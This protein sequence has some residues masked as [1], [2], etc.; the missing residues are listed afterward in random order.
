MSGEESAEQIK[1][2]ADRLKQE[3]IRLLKKRQ[4]R[5][6]R[7]RINDA[8]KRNLN[9][10]PIKTNYNNNK[11]NSSLTSKII[12]SKTYRRKK[13]RSQDNNK[14]IQKNYS[15]NE[16]SLS[17]NI[18][19]NK[20]ISLIKVP[21][22]ATSLNYLNQN[23][24]V[25]TYGENFDE[26]KYKRKYLSIENVE[27]GRIENHTETGLSKD[28]QYLISVTSA[29][30]IYNKKNNKNKN[31]YEYENEKIVNEKEEINENEN[32][33]D[34]NNI[35]DIPEKEVEEIIST[36]TIEKKNLGDNYK[37]YESKHLYK[38]NITSFTTYRRRKERTI[39]GNKQYETRKVKTYTIPQN[40]E[41]EEQN[42]PYIE[43][44]KIPYKEEEYI[45]GDKDYNYNEEGEEGEGEGE[46]EKEG[47][48]QEGGY[49][50]EENYE[51]E[52]GYYQ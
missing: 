52:E 26:K 27:D 45:L 35:C 41:F 20:I 7:E 17:P 48:R 49:E 15:S 34:D 50:E 14:Y 23:K 42:Q 18:K 47:E 33:N 36:V 24:K 6:K 12:K 43:N 29:E 4:E 44:S 5:L 28:G 46:E 11:Y 25:D 13:N 8:K 9:K 37:F 19:K 16:Y 38:P 2:R 10:I 40:Y 32:Y 21:E 30:K 22:K 51:E 3:K 1:L 31:E 39:Y